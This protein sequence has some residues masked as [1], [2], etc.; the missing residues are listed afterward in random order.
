MLQNHCVVP[1]VQIIGFKQQD[2]GNWNICSYTKVGLIIVQGP[3][4]EIVL[5][6]IGVSTMYKKVSLAYITSHQHYQQDLH[7]KPHKIR[8]LSTFTHILPGCK[9][10]KSIRKLC[11][12][13]RKVFRASDRLLLTAEHPEQ[14]FRAS[15]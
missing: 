11:E 2:I 14:V 12:I 13:P 5:N 6:K 15:P 3:N 8:T 7:T 9:A 1:F 4:N 10:V